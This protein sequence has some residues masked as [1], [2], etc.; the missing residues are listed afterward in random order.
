MDRN[1]SDC[2]AAVEVLGKIGDSR[3]IQPMIA[4]LRNSGWKYIGNEVTEAFTRIGDPAVEPLLAAMGDE[5]S[6]VRLAALRALGEI[7]DPIALE[8]IARALHD[9]NDDVRQAAADA[10]GK[11]GTSG[12]RIAPLRPARADRAR[13]PPPRRSAGS[14]IRAPLTPLIA[15]IRDEDWSVRS[16]AS[17]ALAKLG[18][19]AV[20]PLQT[21]LRDIDKKVHQ[22]AA[23][24]L[25]KLGWHPGNDETGAYYWIAKQNW[26]KCAALGP[27]A[28]TPL[29]DMRN[30]KDP[31][32]RKAIVLVFGKINDPRVIEP[33]VL[34][35]GDENGAVRDTAA[36]TLGK[37]GHGKAVRPLIAALRDESW[38]V[39]KAAAESLG[40]IGDKNAF[41]PL[42]EALGDA[43]NR[44]REAAAEA[45]GKTGNP[46]AVEPLIGT[47]ESE[48][49]DL[50]KAAAEALG[51]IG[52][53]RAVEPLIRALE[54]DYYELF[55]A[56]LAKRKERDPEAEKVLI[57]EL[58][59]KYIFIREAAARALGQI[60]DARAVEP[61]IAAMKYVS[62]NRAGG[63]GRGAR[64]DR[65]RPRRPPADRNPQG[66]QRRRARRLGRG[67]DQAGR[68][69]RRAADR[70][71]EGRA[72]GGAPGG[73]RC[74]GQDRRRPRRRSAYPRAQG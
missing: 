13:R 43:N 70:R 35:L 61:L 49:E 57:G 58:S 14:A 40:N 60:G 47:L 28:I 71:T 33:L 31:E 24:S 30:I 63:V 67:A 15:A 10:L 41:E 4:L 36:E 20:A 27:Q 42:L 1:W 52:D 37:I 48:S 5:E 7:G 46:F 25:D 23:E 32:I 34:S 44:V 39:R 69:R 38:S 9:P 11:A 29:L 55:E 72:A 64:H 56:T 59:E 50:R 68:S 51:R 12:R 74:A 3:A 2:R 8:P 19:P 45:L 65:R 62:Q 18:Q 53:S 21:A 17:D 16:A 6:D 54:W 26:V 73:H 22:C 66:P